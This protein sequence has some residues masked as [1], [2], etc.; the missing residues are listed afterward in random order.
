MLV[1][2]V[3]APIRRQAINN[4]HSDSNLI[5]AS[6]V[7]I[8]Q[9]KYRVGSVLEATLLSAYSLICC[10][11]LIMSWHKDGSDFESGDTLSS[12]GEASIRTRAFREYALQHMMTSWNGKHVSRYWP[13]VWGIHRSPVNSPHKG[14]W[15]GA[16]MF[17]LI[18]GWINDWVNNR[19]AGD[20][21]RYRAHY[22][23]TVMRLNVRSQTDWGAEDQAKKIRDSP[24]LWWEIIQPTR[25]HCRYWQRYIFVV[26]LW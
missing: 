1:A 3:L 11:I 12:S 19:E 16:L 24:S 15:C 8:T 18:C 5:A 7:H 17:S 20:L 4:D 23:V 13:F 2:D 25:R 14:Q 10:L 6:V 22:D 21:R 9:R 26:Q